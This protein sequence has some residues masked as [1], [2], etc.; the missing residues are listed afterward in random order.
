MPA[1]ICQQE[2]CWPKDAGKKNK[3]T[4]Q[5]DASQNMSEKYEKDA[6][7]MVKRCLRIKMLAERSMDKK[8]AK[9]LLAKKMP[10]KQVPTKKIQAKQMPAKDASK[11]LKRCYQTKCWPK[12]AGKK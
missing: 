8:Q 9:K 10:A 7:M 2:R 11:K 3:D 1:K 5:K 12:D 6:G 4:S